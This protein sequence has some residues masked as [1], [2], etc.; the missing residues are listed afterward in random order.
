MPLRDTVIWAMEAV[1]RRL[2]VPPQEVRL[3]RDS[4]PEIA[5]APLLEGRKALVTGAGPNIGR[6]I[7]LEMARQGAEVYFTEIA[8]AQ[9]AALEGEL[10]AN[11]WRGRGFLSD[12]SKT[13]EI[14]RLCADLAREGVQIDILVNN[15]CVSRNC[16]FDALDLDAMRATFEA[17]VFGPLLLTKRITD[18]LRAAGRAGSVLFLTSIH[19]DEIYG[20]PAY[21]SSKA[22]VAMVVKEL[23]ISLAPAGIR[24]N[25]IAPS[26]VRSNGGALPSLPKVPLYQSSIHPDHIGRAAVFLAADYFSQFTTGTTLTIDAGLISQSPWA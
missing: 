18:T 24:V 25:G 20:D 1:L 6:S 13:D 15:A 3:I 9:I 12:I 26:A 17:N 21:S 8:S 22:A 7:V 19:Q 14:E 10:A 4:S 11:G 23:A 5:G 2:A 16:S